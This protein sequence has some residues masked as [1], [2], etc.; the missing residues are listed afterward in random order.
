MAIFRSLL[1]LAAL[2]FAALIV[3]AAKAGDFSGAG[4]WLT[5]HPW[6]IVTLIDLYIGFAIS[7][8]VIA[9]FV[10]QVGL[11]AVVAPSCGSCPCPF[12][13]MSGLWSGWPLPCRILP[14]GCADQTERF[15][16]I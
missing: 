11:G 5:S 2:A 4:T 14:G 15:S 16:M 9:L 10:V 1:G 12:W 8:V 13:E 7:A 3:W 6:G